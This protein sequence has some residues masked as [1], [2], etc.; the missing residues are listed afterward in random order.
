MG[1]G[2]T[3]LGSRYVQLR[4]PVTQLVHLFVGLN[5]PSPVLRERGNEGHNGS[6]EYQQDWDS[7]RTKTTV[8]RTA[9][10]IRGITVSPD[11]YSVRMRPTFPPSADIACPLLEFAFLGAKVEDF[12]LSLF[13]HCGRNVSQAYLITE[14]EITRWRSVPGPSCRKGG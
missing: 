3:A 10:N 1:N 8:Q 7:G 2:L 11:V 12:G 4:F 6:R 9:R 13:D 14:R 5:C